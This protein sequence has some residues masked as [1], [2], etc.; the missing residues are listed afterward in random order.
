[1]TDPKPHPLIAPL[2]VSKIKDEKGVKTLIKRL[3]DFHGWFH[4]MPAANGFGAQGI[5]DHLA[6]KSGVFL[7]VEAKH[8]NN[9]PK[10]MQKGFGLQIIANDAYAFC[11]NEKNIDHLA[12]WLESFEASVAFVKNGGDPEDIPQEHGARMLNAIAVLTDLWRD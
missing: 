8:G 1:V 3:L 2:D 12:M 5:S 9:K 6:I 10:P 7:A 11:V 4:W